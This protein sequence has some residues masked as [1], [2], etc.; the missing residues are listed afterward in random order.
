MKG[1]LGVQVGYDGNFSF[2]S[3]EKNY[4]RRLGTEARGRL[5]SGP[6]VA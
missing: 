2:Q 3:V 6:S 5:R 4:Q 1:K